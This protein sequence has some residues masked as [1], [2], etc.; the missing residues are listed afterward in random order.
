MT[1]SAD[2]VVVGAGVIGLAC[3]WRIAQ[4][5]LTVAVVERGRCGQGAS[6]VPLAALWP[7]SAAD[8]RAPARCHRESLAM[9]QGF[10]S[11]L[12]ACTGENTGYSQPGRLRL[13][14]SHAQLRRAEQELAASRSLAADAPRFPLE[15]ID[16]EAV[17]AAE[18]AVTA[19]V[20]GA[21]ACP[22]SAQVC[23]K[24][25]LAALK[26][27][28]LASGARLHENRAATSCLLRGETAT[29]VATIT[30]PIAS[31]AVVV[32][33]GAWAGN[34]LGDVAPPPVR[35]VKGHV[36]CLAC[37]EPPCRRIIQFDRMYV[38]S[39]PGCVLLGSTTEPDA[40]FDESIDPS[41]AGDL[42]RRAVARIPALAE[43]PVLET[44][45]GIRA[46]PRNGHPLV[47]PWPATKGL[48]VATGFYKTGI[49]M[50]PL[51]SLAIAAMLAQGQADPELTG[52]A[53]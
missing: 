35:P 16:A 7:A 5:G 10:V 52:F 34:L 22:A 46:R 26:T 17:R 19:S 38:V 25:L 49:A 28:C 48:F 30:G 6:G 8:P 43:L 24:A 27:A 33:A 42:A 36:I 1:E 39:H 4:R 29:G 21:L 12:E 11:E 50:A 13:I 37:G 15:I 47:G 18:P 44:W 45:A 23:T 51:V 3:A 53:M 14:F 2:V 9:Y 20:L 31:R 32:A 41:I 40:L